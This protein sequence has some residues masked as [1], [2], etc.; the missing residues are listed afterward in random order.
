MIT[1]TDMFLMTGKSDRVGICH[2]NYQYAKANSKY[3]KGYDEN[4]E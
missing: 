2:T 1:D 4:K 3:M